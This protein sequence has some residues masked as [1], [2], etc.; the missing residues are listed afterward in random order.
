MAALMTIARFKDGELLRQ[1]NSDVMSR[2]RATR[3][4]T[5]NGSDVSAFLDEIGRLRSGVGSEGENSGL[6]RLW[7]IS[8]EAAKGI[9][10]VNNVTEGLRYAR[11]G[12][13]LAFVHHTL[14]LR[15]VL[16]ADDCDLDEFTYQLHG[17]HG[18]HAVAV[19]KGAGYLHQ[20]NAAVTRLSRDGT[21]HALKTK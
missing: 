19:P 3:I 13:E 16:S 1:I 21:W 14:P 8:H 18:G 15:H 2:R 6:R 11:L 10:T 20:I 12:Q 5:L 9:T 4:L 7:Q 17:V